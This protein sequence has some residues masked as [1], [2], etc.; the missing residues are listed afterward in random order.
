MAS[1][2][3][4]SP[5]RRREGALIAITLAIVAFAI[6]AFAYAQ[7]RKQEEPPIG[8][9]RFD[10][11]LMPTCDC[12]A[13]TAPLSFTL[14]ESQ[15]LD[16]TVVDEEG[17]TVRTLLSGEPQESGRLTLQWDGTDARG[18]PVPAGNY[19]LRLDL[20]EPP[21]TIVIPTDVRVER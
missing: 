20:T 3:Q 15:P 18:A 5:A 14:S 4:R 7:V 1:T 16:A 11:R 10:S 12:P 2:A 6:A 13:D 17:N 19:R 8:G 9:I 21:R